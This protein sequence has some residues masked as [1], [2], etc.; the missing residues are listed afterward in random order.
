VVW[1]EQYQKDPEGGWVWGNHRE[2]TAEQM[3]QMKDM[4]RSHKECFA[5]SMAELPGYKDPVSIGS[6]SGAPAYCR[7]KQYSPVEKQIIQQKGEELRD[8][9]VIVQLPLDN[10]FAARP[11]IAAK[12][13][14]ETGEWT[15]HR[16]CV[17]YIRQN[18]NTVTVPHA[19]P[20]PETIFRSFGKARYFSKLDMRSGFHQLVLDEE[21]QRRTAFWW[22]DELWAYKRL[23]F[24]L[25][26]SSAVYQ[27]VMDTVLTEAKVRGFSAAFVDD[28]LVWSDTPEEHVQHV[29]AVLAALS[30]VGLKAHPDKSIFMAE[31]VEYLGHIVSP[32]GLQPHQARTAAFKQLQLPKTKDELSS[33]LGML[34]FY[35]CYLPNYS[36]I[37]EPLRRM[38]KKDSPAVPAVG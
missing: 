4:I 27:R 7:P 13:D 24:G 19:L 16:F 23:P 9:G 8:A 25:K 5:Y 18:Q 30:A 1:S 28:V 20:L 2:A 14:A 31:G 32:A 3:Q 34:G 37:A 22:G 10:A 26:N 33:Q 29:Q 12:K 11:T 21:S 15:D 38:R 6:Y 35:R 17:N 36:Q